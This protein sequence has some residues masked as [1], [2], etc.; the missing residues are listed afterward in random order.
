M[1]PEEYLPFLLNQFVPDGMEEGDLPTWVKNLKDKLF[2]TV[3]D[4]SIS[5]KNIY[6]ITPTNTKEVYSK[7]DVTATSAFLAA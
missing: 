2:S 5:L 4:D 1:N 7:G 3:V 6:P